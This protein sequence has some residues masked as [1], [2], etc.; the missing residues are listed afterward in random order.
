MD[1]YV[2]YSKLEFSIFYGTNYAF[3]SIHIGGLPKSTEKG[4]WIR[5]RKFSTINYFEYV[6]HI[7]YQ[8]SSNKI[9][10]ITHKFYMETQLGKTTEWFSYIM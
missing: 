10:H 5:T 3:W 9:M 6:S 8:Q 2:E 7:E 1:K 4:R